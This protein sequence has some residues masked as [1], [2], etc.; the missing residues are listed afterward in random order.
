VKHSKIDKFDL[1]GKL[2]NFI[3][4]NSFKT[5]ANSNYFYILT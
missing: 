3:Y 4:I 1:K 2:V 5:H